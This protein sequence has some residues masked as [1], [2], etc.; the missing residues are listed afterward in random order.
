MGSSGGNPGDDAD[1]FAAALHKG[2]Q[3]GIGAEVGGVDGSG[4]ERLH[5]CR[6]RGE[7]LGFQCGGPKVLGEDAFSHTD[8][9]GPVG[10]VAKVA[11]FE[12]GGRGSIRSCYFLTAL[13]VHAGHGRTCP[14]EGNK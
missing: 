9:C 14:D 3:G 1:G 10:D 8:K 7:H 2:V 12:D 11:K 6:P 4:V 5:G 13:G